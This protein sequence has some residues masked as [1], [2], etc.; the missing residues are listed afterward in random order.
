M[1]Q[2]DQFMHVYASQLFWLGI[3]LAILYFGV[4]HMMLPKIEGTIDAR[5]G[6]IAGDI[7]AAES[8]Q[9]SAKTLETTWRAKMSDAQSSAQGAIA[10]A[11]SS[12]G[13]NM[14]AQVAKADAA[15]NAQAETAYAGIAAAQTAAAA[16]IATV[17][18]E[19]AQDLV[20]K[21]AGLTVTP[22][23]ALTAVQEVLANG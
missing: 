21:V 18:G 15:L 12:A 7:A 13:A 4:G 6:Q 5:Q 20:A 11:K 22:S 10:E 23:A 3:V 2:L 9:Q 14:A 8:A 19:A 17:A 1:P 16:H